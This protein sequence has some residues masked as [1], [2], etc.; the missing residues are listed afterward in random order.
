VET[1]P[2]RL[3]FYLVEGPDTTLV[4]VSAPLVAGLPQMTKGSHPTDA[5]HLF[6]SH[7]DLEEVQADPIASKYL[8]RFV[9]AAEMLRGI[10]R[11]CLWLAGATQTELRASRVLQE[12]AQRVA[13]FRQGSPTQSVRDQARTPWLFTQIRQP[14]ARYLALPKVSSENRDY[15]PAA[16]FEPDVIAGDA[17]LTV[18]GATLWLFGYLQSAAFTA[19]AKTFTG[20]LKSDLQILPGLVYFPFPFVVP[21]VRQRAGLEEAA[22]AVLEERG[23]HSGATLAELY[24]SQEMPAALRACHRELDVQIDGLY[25]LSQPTEMSR[26][27]AVMRKYEELIAPLASTS[28]TKRSRR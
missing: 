12:R 9:G 6:V 14:T 16:F 8:R 19:W 5:G 1:R 22:R 13:E 4:K 25:G 27:K 2:A 15:I 7:A 26:M 24:D 21:T 3:N 11:H 23:R 17:L 18:T 28:S 10:D 20:R